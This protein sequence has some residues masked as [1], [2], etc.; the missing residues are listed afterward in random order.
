MTNNIPVSALSSADLARVRSANQ[1]LKAEMYLQRPEVVFTMRLDGDLASL[2]GVA[3]LPYDTGDGTATDTLAGMTVYVSGVASGQYEK[4]VC[5]LRKPVP[6]DDDGDLSINEVSGIN[7]EDGDYLTVVKSMTIWQKDVRIVGSNVYMDYDRLFG[8]Y[9]NTGPIPRIGPIVSVIQQ[10]TGDITFTPPSP[11]LSATYDDGATIASYLYSA[12]GATSTSDM[13]SGTGT[14]SW[15]YP[16]TANKEYLWSCKVTDNEG[17]CTTSFRWV[18]V[19]PTKPQFELL[20]LSYQNGWSFK[21]K[22]NSMTDVY[23]RAMCVLYSDQSYNGIAYNAGKM[24]GFM[25]VLAVGWIDGETIFENATEGYVEFEVK[26][27]EFWLSKIRAFP[28]GVDDVSAEPTNWTEIKE[29]T[30]DKALAHMLYQCSTMV[31]IC[32]CFFTGNDIRIKSVLSAADNLWGQIGDIAFATI[33]AEAHVNALG[34]LF[35]EIP[36]ILLSPTDQNSVPVVMDIT[37]AD[38]IE[39]LDL[40]LL[41]RSD[42]SSLEMSGVSEWDGSTAIGLISKAPGN[43]G[44]TYGSPANEDGYLFENQAECNRITGARFA[45]LTSRFDMLDIELAGQ[46]LMFDVC[47]RQFATIDIEAD[48]NPLGFSMSGVRLVPVGIRFVQTDALKPV[49][50]FEIVPT[51]VRDGVTVIPPVPADS[52]EPYYPPYDSHPPLFPP[53]DTWFPPVTPPVLPPNPTCGNTTSNVYALSWDKSELRG[54]DEDRIARIYFPCKLHVSVG[55]YGTYLSLNGGSIPGV[56]QMLGDAGTHWH[57][58]AIK[59]GVRV[60]SSN[61]YYKFYPPEP[62]DVD[63]FELELDEGI[64]SDID[65][66]PM[67]IVSSGVVQANDET[68]IAVT[69]IIDKYY[70][71]EGWGLWWSGIGWAYGCLFSGVASLGEEMPI[72]NYSRNFYKATSVSHNVRVADY[73]F[74]DNAGSSKYNVRNVRADGRRIQLG[75]VYILNVCPAG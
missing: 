54:D 59:N 51:E 69:T 21:V 6:D 35:V 11:A 10:A 24:A 61:E 7:F 75:S 14:A 72:E 60:I 25:N 42:V 28:F 33:L 3:V 63:G 67:D 46:V 16:T 5:R 56:G 44:N 15:V 26:G 55:G 29:L 31:A 49:I 64:G 62:M 4:G 17:R 66:V 30:V 18:I 73:Q 34:Q 22:T 58:Y 45:Q 41:G 68:G 57:L 74:Y 40:T 2:D 32:D 36:A 50:T 27:A 23:D 53:T 9:L 47:P 37:K 43:I 12:P 39:G 48:D 13:T 70:A 38:Y 71:V 19:N 20:D 1:F 65:Y 8:S 52:D